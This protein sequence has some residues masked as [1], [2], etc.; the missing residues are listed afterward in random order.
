M[1]PFTSSTG[2]DKDKFQQDMA[3]LQRII[4]DLEKRLDKQ[5]RVM[6]AMYGVLKDQL[7]VD[8]ATLIGKL[9][10]VVREKAN[11]AE[12]ECAQCGRRL[13]DKKK[14][15]YCGEER[16]LESVFDLL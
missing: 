11:Q 16:K 14:C 1:Q 8:N 5:S 6:E 9:A 12:L 4:G 7:K 15:M 3:K 13:G 2:V 10:E